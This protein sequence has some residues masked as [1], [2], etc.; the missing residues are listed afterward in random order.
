LG[1]FLISQS[2]TYRQG[3]LAVV[4]RDDRPIFPPPSPL[5]LFKIARTGN[6][7]I[8]TPDPTSKLDIFHFQRDY[9]N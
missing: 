3:E 9:R 2:L 5:T 6:V 1:I 8:G 7:G 4:Q